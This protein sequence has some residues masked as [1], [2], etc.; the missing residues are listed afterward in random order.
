LEGPL[1]DMIWCLAIIIRPRR[2]SWILR[3]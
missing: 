2:W 1:T 3:P